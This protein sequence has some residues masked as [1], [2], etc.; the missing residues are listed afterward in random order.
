MSKIP[1]GATHW[2]PAEGEHR[3]EAYWRPD[4]RG[5]YDCW[6][7]CSAGHYW[8][9]NNHP[10]P[11]YAKPLA[12]T[13]NG[14]EDGLPPVGLEVEI[15]LCNTPDW[16]NWCRAKILFAKDSALVFEWVAEGV[17]HPVNLGQCEIRPIGTAEQ[18][19][20]EAH[21]AKYMPELIK[22]WDADTER[23]EFLEAVYALIVEAGK[24]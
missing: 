17:A 18:L 10:L 13:W 21:R 11:D 3:V 20:A 9:T 6:A 23:T 22:L 8:Q 24:P 4:A 5:G 19:A 16:S 7:V 12:S 1:E 2:S 15:R 14:S